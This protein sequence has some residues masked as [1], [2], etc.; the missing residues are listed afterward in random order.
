MVDATRLRRWVSPGSR[1]PPDVVREAGLSDSFVS[2]LRYRSGVR[3]LPIGLGLSGHQPLRARVECRAP[4]IGGY[5]RRQ[6]R[7]HVTPSRRTAP[8]AL[9]ATSAKGNGSVH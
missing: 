6:G 1:L 4:R 9:G 5:P 8:I 7:R 3:V 2:G